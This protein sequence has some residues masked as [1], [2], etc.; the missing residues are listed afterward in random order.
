MFSYVR[1][2]VKTRI[3]TYENTKIRTYGIYMKFASSYKDL[4][5]WRTAMDL[6]KLIY[7]ITKGFPREELFGLTSQMRR[8]AISVVS[9][10]AEGFARRS[11]G[12]KRYLMSVAVG[13]LA[14]LGTQLELAFELE[15][16]DNK[17]KEIISDKIDHVGKMISN[18]LKGTIK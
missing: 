14:E 11:F 2:F 13:S 7:K 15:Y 12:E 17:H 1:V 18:F 5:M 9:N 8:A 3:Q 10:I 6:C 4:E 16:V